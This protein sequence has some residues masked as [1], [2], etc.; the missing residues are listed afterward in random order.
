MEINQN[1]LNSALETQGLPQA[2]TNDVSTNSPEL[3]YPTFLLI[4]GEQSVIKGLLRDLLAC[5]LYGMYCSGERLR[6]MCAGS[7]RA[8]TC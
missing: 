7:H 8:V 6:G 2:A 4:A 5:Y 3:Y 1:E